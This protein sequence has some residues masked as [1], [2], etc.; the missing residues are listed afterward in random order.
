M[1]NPFDYFD[2]IHCINLDERTDRWDDIQ[3]EF[4]KA[5]IRDRVI[6]FPAIKDPDGRIGVIKS[7]LTIVKSALERGLNNVLIFEDDMIFIKD[8]PNKYLELAIKET[9]GI[10]W[11]L[12]F[13]GANTHTRLHKLK[14][15]L[16][17]LKNA[18]AC[19]AYA[20][21]KNIFIPF[22]NKF[23]GMNQ[24]RSHGDIL[25]VY[26]AQ[27]IQAK[28]TCLLVNPM[29]CTQKSDYSDIEKR[30]VNQGYIEQRFKNNIK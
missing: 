19:H 2:E 12:F 21:N 14:P 16:V 6:R 17:L 20:L 26:I 18:F 10:D 29:L 8:N 4:D 24:I 9:E 13:L 28:K 23:D 15:H 3:K 30:E 5:G 1:N 22:I 25:D 11:S 27:E 7:N